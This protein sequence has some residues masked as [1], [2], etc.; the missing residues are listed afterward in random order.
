[1]TSMEHVLVNVVNAAGF[2]GMIPATVGAVELESRYTEEI[3]QREEA[4]RQEQAKA[5]RR[6]MIR[7][8][9]E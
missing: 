5:R 8:G 9:C 2:M 4:F 6:R 7:F 1:M 3:D